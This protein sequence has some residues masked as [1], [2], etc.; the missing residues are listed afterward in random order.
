MFSFLKQKKSVEAHESTGQSQEKSGFFSRLKAGLAKTR[1]SFSTGI[2]NLILGKKTLDKEVLELI[3]TQLLTADVGIEATQQLIDHL[4][5]KLAR[6]E[7]HDTETA[8]AVLQE[9]LKTILRPCEQPFNINEEKKP[10]VIL[11]VG[12]NGSGKTTT[13]GKLAKHLQ[14][15]GKKSFTRRRR[16]ISCCCN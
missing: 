12:I 13:I 6:N 16:Y 11:V 1:A 10:L 7:L 5:Q 15:S 8:L 3:E 9:D 4:T 14:A 2:A